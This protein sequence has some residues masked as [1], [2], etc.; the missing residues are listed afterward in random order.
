MWFSN[1]LKKTQ[2]NNYGI[3]IKTMS[4][5]FLTIFFSQK[6]YGTRKY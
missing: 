3:A 1:K 5:K 2:H 6:D 4:Y